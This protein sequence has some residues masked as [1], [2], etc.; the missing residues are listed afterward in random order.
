MTWA[1]EEHTKAKHDLLLAFFHKWVSIHSGHF[2]QRGGGLVRV[3]DGFAG[4]GVYAGG[5]PG[6]PRILME[7][8][9]ENDNLRGRWER[10]E[11]EFTFVEQD[12]RRADTLRRILT[13][14]EVAVRGAARWTDRV[15]WSVTCGRYEEHVPQDVP[16]LSALFLFLD[17][18]GYSHSPMTLTQDL[19]QQ[20]K[21]DTLIFLPLSF[22]HRFADRAGQDAALDRF[23]GTPKWR[24]VPNGPGRPRTLLELFQEELRA[25][26]LVWVLPFRLK[27]PD[28]GNEYWIVGA[29]GHPAGFESIKQGFWTVDPRNGQGF[30][31]PR[32]AA[33]GQE[34]FD[35]VEPVVP[36]PNTAPLLAMLRGRFGREPFTVEEAVEFTKTTRFLESHLRRATLAPAETA[37]QLQV[38]RPAGVRQFPE[39]RGIIMQFV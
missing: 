23:F 18:F 14:Y 17:P 35:F 28:R 31:A 15:R 25:A 3:F 13:E 34:T 26:G 12:P 11:F 39:A 33:A 16:G 36:G 5:E 1:R 19:V 9:F 22:V 10:V 38:R 27:P 2:T 20:P 32:A 4:P 30:A 29:S 7:A 37:D 8:L 6:S 24:D 21:S